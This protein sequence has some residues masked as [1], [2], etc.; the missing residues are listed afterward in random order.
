MSRTDNLINSH[1]NPYLVIDVPGLVN[2]YRLLKSDI[3]RNGE[4]YMSQIRIRP[5]LKADYDKLIDAVISYDMNNRSTHIAGDAQIGGSHTVVGTI[6]LAAVMYVVAVLLYRYWNN[7]KREIRTNKQSNNRVE[8][9]GGISPFGFSSSG[10]TMPN[11]LE[12]QGFRDPP[13]MTTP[14]DDPYDVSIKFRDTHGSPN[15][16]DILSKIVPKSLIDEAKGKGKEGLSAAHDVLAALEVIS[17]ALRV[18]DETQGEW[19]ERYSKSAVK[20]GLSIGAAVLSAGAGGDNAVSI[21]FAVG[22]SV[23]MVAKIF[24]KLTEVA[25]K[26]QKIILTVQKSIQTI[27]PVVDQIQRTVGTGVDLAEMMRAKRLDPEQSKYIAKYQ[28]YLDKLESAEIQMHFIYDLFNI[29][30]KGG[31]S[32]VAAKVSYVLDTYLN[33]EYL[34]R[35][36][37]ALF[38]IINEIYTEINKVVMGFMG[39]LMDIMLPNSMGLL[40]VVSPLLEDSFSAK[41][42]TYARN[43]LSLKWLKCVPEDMKIVLEYPKELEYMI[44]QYTQYLRPLLGDNEA[45]I[46]RT[47]SIAARGI[48]KGMSL[49]FM[50]L[51]LFVIFSDINRGNIAFGGMDIEY[52]INASGPGTCAQIKAEMD[53]V[54]EAGQTIA[55]DAKR[56]ARDPKGTTRDATHSVTRAG[57]RLVTDRSRKQIER[58][59]QTIRAE[60]QRISSE[61]D[62]KIAESREYD[63]RRVDEYMREH[64]TR[65][66]QA[67]PGMQSGQFAREK[68]L[69]VVSRAQAERAA[70]RRSR[71]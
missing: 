32:C 34:S 6:G 47:V 41:A 69:A 44:G 20:V 46:G 36:S 53:R 1:E 9:T 56:R 39:T 51:N 28:K 27:R 59:S 31:P 25:Y 40:G 35:H 57:K 37:L 65:P 16:I 68:H 22:K 50:F 43:D 15:P 26:I 54:K 24:T 11:P 61:V 13:C 33:D 4:Y 30:F 67:M 71:R 23:S 19:Y 49:V 55:K 66:D 60:K 62:R 45:K 42:Y 7:S 2:S 21:P 8:Q 17:K 52:V 14:E 38:C 5:N 58:G 63:Q 48:N 64:R 29:D 10:C 70:Q 12:V 3:D 18:I